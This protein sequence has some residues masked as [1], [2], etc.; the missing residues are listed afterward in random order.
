ML[1]VLIFISILGCSQKEIEFK[2][3]MRKN[4]FL[5][6]QDIVVELDVISNLDKEVIFYDID[7]DPVSLYSIIIFDSNNKEV[8]LSCPYACFRTPN[9][10]FFDKKNTITILPHTSFK[11]EMTLNRRCQKDT[12]HY[13]YDSLPL[14]KYTLMVGYNE[15]IV[16]N[17]KSWGYLSNKIAFEIIE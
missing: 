4:T 15:T 2:I 11:R 12:T 16:G 9:E 14:G 3:E 8:K 17:E 13:Y 6:V 10:L 7:Y 5:K 1:K